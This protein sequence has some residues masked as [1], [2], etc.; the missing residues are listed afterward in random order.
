MRH[1]LRLYQSRFCKNHTVGQWRAGKHSQFTGNDRGQ[2]PSLPAWPGA[3]AVTAVLGHLT[4]RL[5]AGFARGGV[6]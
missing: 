3:F 5:L 1:L 6:D 4:A 2:A